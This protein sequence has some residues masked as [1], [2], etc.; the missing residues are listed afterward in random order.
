MPPDCGPPS[1]KET[2]PTRGA[3]GGKAQN[4]VSNITAADQPPQDKPLAA[5]VLGRAGWLSPKEL[6]RALG[7]WWGGGYGVATCPLCGFDPPSLRVTLND[8][9]PDLRCEGAGCRSAAIRDCLRERG[10]WPMSP[11]KFQFRGVRRLAEQV[12][13]LPAA[14]AAGVPL[15][16]TEAARYFETQRLPVPA[17]DDLRCCRLVSPLT[18]HGET[19]IV[20]AFRDIDGRVTAHRAY[21]TPGL[22]NGPSHLVQ[23]ELFGTALRLAPAG[24]DLALAVGLDEGAAAAA[25]IDK[26]IWVVT[27]PGLLAAAPIPSTVKRVLILHPGMSPA[28]ERAKLALQ[29][30]GRSVHVLPPPDGA[31][32]FAMALRAR[33]NG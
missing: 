5:T 23:G 11:C 33:R 18:P 26:P 19:V 10:L 25:L 30:P 21:P 9:L 15:P 8:P 29:R 22:L 7:G 17:T 1:E 16:G 2:P 20:A 28:V 4:S 32:S 6:T 31:G 3:S 27:D 12:S 24:P 13:A 14:W